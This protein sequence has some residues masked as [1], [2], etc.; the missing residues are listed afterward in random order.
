MLPGKDQ[1]RD[2]DTGNDCNGKVKEDGDD[3]HYYQNKGIRFGHMLDTFDG[4]ELEGP[5]THHEHDPHQ[6]GNRNG[7]DDVGEHHHKGNEQDS[8]GEG[9]E[10]SQSARSEVD[11]GLTYHRTPCHT[12]EEPRSGIAHTQGNT[13]FVPRTTFSTHLIEYG[14]R[15]KGFNE[16]HKRNDHRCRYDDLERFRTEENGEIRQEEVREGDIGEIG[17]ISDSLGIDTQEVDSKCDDN[18]GDKTCRNGLADLWKVL[19]GGHRKDDD[20]VHDVVLGNRSFYDLH[21]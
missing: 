8:C 16:P 14:E 18:N 4:G 2:D 19:H 5:D 21:P 10:P 13:L 12:A 17:H 20:D 9:G 15:Q 7:R 1:C 6:Y 11:D 3:G